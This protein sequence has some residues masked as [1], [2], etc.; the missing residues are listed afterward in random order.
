MLS[1]HQ[2][3]WVQFFKHFP[4]VTL[5]IYLSPGAVKY[6]QY[7][8]LY[9]G[10]FRLRSAFVLFQI[11]N[12]TVCFF[13][14]FFFHCFL[15]L[16]CWPVLDDNLLRTSQYNARNI[17]LYEIMLFSSADPDTGNIFR[18]ILTTSKPSRKIMVILCIKIDLV[19]L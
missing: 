15:Y 2:I 16:E 13:F 3:N 1:T 17:I 9:Q 4:G 7:F 5:K 8:I 18:F 19:S 6:L 12:K 10:S 11:K 14:S